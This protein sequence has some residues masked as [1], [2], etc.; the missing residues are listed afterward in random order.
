VIVA[1]YCCVVLCCVYLPVREST[2][3]LPGPS[4]VADVKE[5]VRT[6]LADNDVDLPEAE[7]ASGVCLTSWGQSLPVCSIIGRRREGLSLV[8]VSVTFCSCLVNDVCCLDSC[9]LC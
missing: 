2:G 8:F 7:L 5:L 6:L 4:D 9:M 1:S 3:R